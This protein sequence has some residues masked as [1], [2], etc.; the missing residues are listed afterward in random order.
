MTDA[1]SP[2]SAAVSGG[3]RSVSVLP[4]KYG[5]RCGVTERQWPLC[6]K[7]CAASGRLA[8]S[9]PGRVEKFMGRYDSVQGGLLCPGAW[10]RRTNPPLAL[11]TRVPVALG[12]LAVSAISAGFVPP[13]GCS[14]PGCQVWKVMFSL[15][16]LFTLGKDPFLVFL[17]NNRG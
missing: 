2:S 13:Q 8:V 5:L 16:Y 15:P 10:D 1:S 7:V 3:S 9:T 4:G 14:T 11:G 12:V 17:W 6:P